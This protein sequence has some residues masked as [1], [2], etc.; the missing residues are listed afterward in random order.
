MYVVI[1]SSRALL[2][3]LVPL[4]LIGADDPARHR[5]TVILSN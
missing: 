3:A 4:A 5:H 1:H 2:V